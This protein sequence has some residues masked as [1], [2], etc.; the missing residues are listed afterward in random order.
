MTSSGESKTNLVAAKRV[1][2]EGFSIGFASE[3]PRGLSGYITT[4]WVLDRPVPGSYDTVR[5]R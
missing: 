2:A 1:F 3:T 5:K 4:R